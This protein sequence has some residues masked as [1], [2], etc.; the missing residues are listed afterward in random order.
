[1]TLDF[2]LLTRL[3]LLLV[4]FLHPTVTILPIGLKLCT[5]ILMVHMDVHLPLP[6]IHQA[7]FLPRTGVLLLL[8]LA[9]G[10]HQMDVRIWLQKK[11]GIPLVLVSI[12]DGRDHPLPL[13]ATL[14]HLFIPTN[15]H[16]HTTHTDIG[17]P[18]I[19]RQL[20]MAANDALLLIVGGLLWDQS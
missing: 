8:E 14:C 19:H 3:V 11:E 4:L 9:M 7:T 12:M 18:T 15:D 16:P 20:I 1:M 17:H 13:M 2:F 6:A 5:T 10:T